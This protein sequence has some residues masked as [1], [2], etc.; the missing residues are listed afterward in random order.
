MGATSA[1]RRR[2]AP[3]RRCRLQLGQELPLRQVDPLAQARRHVR[4]R[5]GPVTR[6]RLAAGATPP[7]ASG[8]RPAA[9]RRLAQLR[10]RV[11]SAHEVGEL[12]PVQRQPHGRVDARP[13]QAR[14]G[15]PSRGREARARDQLPGPGGRLEPEH[16]DRRR[17][18]SREGRRRHRD[19]QRGIGRAAGRGRLHRPRQQRRARQP[20]GHR[21]RRDR[22][23]GRSRSR[24]RPR[25]GA[26]RRDRASRAATRP[27]T[28][29]WAMA[30]SRARVRDRPSGIARPLRNHSRFCAKSSQ[31]SRSSTPVRRA[32]A[33]RRRPR[34][35]K[36][37]PFSLS[38]APWMTSRACVGPAPVYRGGPGRSRASGSMGCRCRLSRPGRGRRRPP[39][40]PP[41]P[42]AAVDHAVTRA[43][44]T[45]STRWTSTTRVRSGPGGGQPQALGVG[46]GGVV[47]TVH[48]H[49][50]GA[51]LAGHALGREPRQQVGDRRRRRG[52]R[53]APPGRDRPARRARRHPAGRRWPRRTRARPRVV[54]DPA[55]GRRR[56]RTRRSGRSAAARARRRSRRGSGPRA[57]RSR[58]AGS[59][60]ASSAGPAPTLTATTTV[61]RVAGGQRG[62]HGRHVVGSQPAPREA[63]DRRHRHV[64]AGPGQ[65]RGG[66]LHARLVL[67]GRARSRAR[68]RAARRRPPAQRS[69]VGAGD[70]Q[71]LAPRGAR[72]AR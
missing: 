35:W 30:F 43:P 34:S 56:T 26:S 69:T 37:R 55:R 41:A 8:R 47:D 42:A 66:R 32:P 28:S 39:P 63:G 50:T 24:G 72:S 16:P 2:T 13:V 51:D 31:P 62:D 36:R 58:T 52:E 64:E 22:R 38:C 71:R 57:T 49:Q 7:P 70:R 10:A 18:D 67:A 12:G 44:S 15:I 19:L 21:P 25:A 1:R 53:R 48:E 23:G 46:H 3:A 40:A 33:A 9:R 45:C 65:Q 6:A 54:D 14:P 61:G 60:A 5:R 68:A 4:G 20:P 59:A 27:S 11:E 29:A 17:I